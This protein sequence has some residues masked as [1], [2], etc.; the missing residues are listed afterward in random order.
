MED[1][2]IFSAPDKHEYLVIKELEDTNASDYE[3]D[4]ECVKCSCFVRWFWILR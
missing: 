1:S 3:E 2:Y 4:I